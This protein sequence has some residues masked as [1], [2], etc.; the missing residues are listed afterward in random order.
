[1]SWLELVD[2]KFA[3]H[4]AT[5]KY[6]VGHNVGRLPTTLEQDLD[7]TL[8]VATGKVTGALH[9]TDLTADSLDAAREKMAVWCERMAYAL[10]AVQR[11]NH[12]LPI[13]ERK[14]V[15]LEELP[16][17]L[18]REYR[19]LVSMYEEAQTD[20]DQENIRAYLKDH[21]INYVSDLVESAQV[22]AENAKESRA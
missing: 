22:E 18:Q 16:L 17:W 5:L 14:S 8:D 10:R 7:L 21:P 20:E 3:D 11:K 2:A 6:T 4:K 19:I 13:F 12:D 1:M 9:L 15:V